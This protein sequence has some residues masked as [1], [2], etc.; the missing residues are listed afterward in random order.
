MD[1]IS[2]NVAANKALLKL[3]NDGIEALTL[4]GADGQQ[5]EVTVD[6]KG[7]LAVTVKKAD[8]GGDTGGNTGGGADGKVITFGG[9]EDYADAPMYDMLEGHFTY[10]V[11]DYVPTEAQMQRAVLKLNIDGFTEPRTFSAIDVVKGGNYNDMDKYL[12]SFDDSIGDDD[13]CAELVIRTKNDPGTYVYFNSVFYSF[14]MGTVT[15]GT[16]IFPEVTA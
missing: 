3:K 2:I 4:N 6:A 12:I 13:V 8:T 7:A 16:I 1:I 15:G 9:V 14:T 11:S 5:Y 10:R